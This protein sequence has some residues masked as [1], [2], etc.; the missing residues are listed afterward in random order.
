MKKSKRCY[1]FCPKSKQSSRCN[2]SLSFPSMHL[3]PS[4]KAQTGNTPTRFQARYCSTASGYFQEIFSQLQSACSYP[5][6]EGLDH[7]HG[8]SW[9]SMQGVHLPPMN[10]V[11]GVGDHLGTKRVQQNPFL[12]PGS[13]AAGRWAGQGRAQLLQAQETP[14]SGCPASVWDAAMP[15]ITLWIE[16]GS[17]GAHVVLHPVSICIC[18][19]LHCTK[20]HL[21]K[22]AS[23]C[24]RNL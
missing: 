15:A 23:D 11:A 13:L 20:Q 14:N 3:T 6:A 8:A 12:G 2:L 16:A 7:S 21:T 18:R 10:A 4:R 22:Q 17:Q 19:V 24:L 1:L 9:G 5:R